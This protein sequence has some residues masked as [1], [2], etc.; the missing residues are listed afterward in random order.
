MIDLD[1]VLPK[2]D[3]KV[4]YYGPTFPEK[5][6]WWKVAA[7]RDR[8]VRPRYYLYR[9]PKSAPT[10]TLE[11]SSV[12]CVVEVGKSSSHTS[13]CGANWLHLHGAKCAEC[14]MPVAGAQSLYPDDPFGMEKN[15]TWNGLRVLPYR[16]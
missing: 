12:G 15:E 4:Y 13:C 11:T 3:E 10:D 2:H 8:D 5:N 6:G 9:G 14:G 7:I 16:S 1:A